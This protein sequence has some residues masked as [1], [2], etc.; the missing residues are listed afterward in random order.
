MKKFLLGSALLLVTGGSM[1]MGCSSFGT[2][3]SEKIKAEFKSSKNFDESQK[4]F[5]NRRPNVIKE[6]KERTFNFKLIMDWLSN[7]TKDRV[8]KSKLPE[9]KPD[10]VSFLEKSDDIK[11]IWFGH[12]SFMLNID[13]KI[14][15]VDPIFSNNAAPV[16]F[17]V[18]RFQKPVLEL[19]ELPKI[20]YIVISH[21]HY[22]H[23]DMKS[24]KHFIDK[25][26]QFITP[27]GVGSHLRGWGIDNNKIV[28]RDWW[29]SVDFD[30][31][32]FTATPAQHF[33]GRTGLHDNE[34]LW[35]S[36]V[37]ESKDKKVFF[38][39][40]SGY[41]NHFKKIGEKFGSF[42]IAFIESGQYNEKWREVHML[43]NESVMAFH[44]LNAK[45]FFPVHWGMFEL[46][47]HSWYEP[48]EILDANK[49]PLPLVIPKLGEL[50]Y[51]NDSYT[52]EKWWKK[53]I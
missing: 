52:L 3:P 12:S 9:V 42:D 13:Q 46:S 36:W 23:L 48:V 20:D 25:P 53:L 27:L 1:L 4:I 19:N 17:M 47:I 40:D 38:S 33:S 10:I 7:S 16:N 51:L 21:D 37:I 24:V 5:V 11:I 41:D 8:P 35:A 28:E 32:K 29:E 34:T 2:R 50:I 14:I 6:M 39:G 15:L 49:D 31:I 18:K 45:K 43:P 44:D 22:D 30:D 26:T